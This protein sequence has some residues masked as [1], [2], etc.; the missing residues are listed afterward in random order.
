YGGLVGVVTLLQI[1][2]YE[3]PAAVRLTGAAGITFAALV[4]PWVVANPSAFYQSTVGGYAEIAP[5]YDS[6]S[7]LALL[8]DW[9]LP[10]PASVLSAIGAALLLGWCAWCWNPW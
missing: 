6:L 9:K 1:V 2:R 5:R 10:A 7:I 4:I 3:R 8:H